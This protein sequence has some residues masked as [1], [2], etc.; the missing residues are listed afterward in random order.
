MLGWFSLFSTIWKTFVFFLSYTF[1]FINILL[2]WAG[3]FQIYNI[4]GKKQSKYISKILQYFVATTKQQPARC[5]QDVAVWL[6]DLIW[7]TLPAATSDE[8]LA[9]FRTLCVFICCILSSVSHSVVPA[10]TV[11]RQ[12]LDIVRYLPLVFQVNTLKS[13]VVRSHTPAPKTLILV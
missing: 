3:I 13:A 7:L 5:Y 2:I 8:L 6:S 4:F 10:I 11:S 12:R 1:T 9:E